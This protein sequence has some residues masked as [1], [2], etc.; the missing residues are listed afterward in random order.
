MQPIFTKQLRIM[1]QSA[2]RLRFLFLL[3][4]LT[5]LALVGPNVFAQGSANI[6]DLNA[7][8]LTNFRSAD[9]TDQQ[10][11][12]F[13]ERANR[14]GVS[15]DQ[16]LELAVTRGLSSSE[17]Q[18]LRSRITGLQDEVA[19]SAAVD[20][21][22]L[23]QQIESNT[24]TSTEQVIDSPV[25]SDVF[26]SNLFRNQTFNLSPSLNI[27]TPSNYQLGA[28]DQLIIT[29]WGALTESARIMQQ[30]LQSEYNVKFNVYNSLTDQ[31][32]QSEQAKIKVQEE[33]PVLTIIQPPLYPLNKSAPNHIIIVFVSTF[34]GLFGS[35]AYQI[36]SPIV[37]KI[38]KDI[39]L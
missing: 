32:D 15:I 10:L 9:I 26:G 13:L 2:I 35:I 33:T 5:L 30:M 23:E 18:E 11:K 36:M 37:S 28:G 17:A 27:P 39:T 29:I 14:Q 3:S 34:L 21:D 25:L 1:V 24:T 4:T 19:V 38:K 6:N 31:S 20:I 7:V 16:A 22:R 12:T 8:N